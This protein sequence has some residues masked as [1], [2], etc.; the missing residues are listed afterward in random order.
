LIG[1][2]ASEQFAE[3]EAAKAELIKRGANVL[4]E[5][6]AA[7]RSEDPEIQRRSNLRWGQ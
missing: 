4:P 7:T 5:L 1:Q 2:L 3:R 6:E